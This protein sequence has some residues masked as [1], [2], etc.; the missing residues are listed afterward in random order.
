MLPLPLFFRTFWIETMTE[1]NLFQAYFNV[2]VCLVLHDRNQ[3]RAKKKAGKQLCTIWSIVV[4]M[5]QNNK[6]NTQHMNENNEAFRNVC[7]PRSAQKS[8][9]KAEPHFSENET[10]KTCEEEYCRREN[11]ELMKKKKKLERKN[12]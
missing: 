12:R 5:V 1:F 11:S 8:E 10:R 4:V 7:R 6:K 3:M 2:F 9:E